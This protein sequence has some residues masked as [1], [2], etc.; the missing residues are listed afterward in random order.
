M[1]KRW[2][3]RSFE[4]MKK[5]PTPPEDALLENSSVDVEKI[6]CF[7]YNRETEKK[8]KVWGA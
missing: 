6:I 5:D 8:T 1:V 2:T 3:K 7:L 4:S